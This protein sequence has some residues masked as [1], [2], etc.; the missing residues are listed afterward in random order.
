MVEQLIPIFCD[1]DD[2]CKGYEEY[3]TQHL[4]MNKDQVI[5]KTS[6]AL[7]EIMTIVI[8]F[9]LSQYR[10]FKWYYKRY[11]CE[12]LREFFPRLVSYSR[13]VE[14]MKSAIAPLTL[15]LIKRCFGKCTGINFVDSTTLDVCDSHRIN[16]NRC[17]R[18]S[19]SAEKAQQ[20]GFMG[21]SCIWQSM[22]RAK[23]YL[24]AL[25]PGM[26]T[27]AIGMCSIVSLA[28]CTGNFSQTRDICRR[29]CLRSCGS[30]IFSS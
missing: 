28:R 20:A 16:S 1:V 15:Y 4:L 9:H 2:F 24:F 22:T 21:S 7:S 13:F 11:V 5:P 23:Y 30:G 10:M 3:C 17:F 6:M 25:H 27:I 8:L 18:V 26:S 12:C 29:S 14:I 19:L